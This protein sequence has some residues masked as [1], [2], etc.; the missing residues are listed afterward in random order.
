MHQNVAKCSKN[1]AKYNKCSK[2]S[3]IH[4]HT[5]KHMNI[6][7][8]HIYYIKNTSTYIKNTS[9]AQQK[10]IKISPKYIKNATE[11]IEIQ[12]NTCG[13]TSKWVAIK[14]NIGNIATRQP[15]REIPFFSH[16][17][18]RVANYNNYYLFWSCI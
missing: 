1:T 7:Q 2:Y 4:E 17:G 12:P 15:K 18:C 5:S 10:H 16:D 3:K 11:I 8:K 6:H 9:N 13:S 14:G